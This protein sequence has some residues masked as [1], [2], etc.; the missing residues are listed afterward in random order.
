MPRRT[1][2]YAFVFPPDAGWRWVDVKDLDELDGTC[3]RCGLPLRY[4]HRLEHRAYPLLLETCLPC[5]ERMTD[6]KRAEL[7]EAEAFLRS[8]TEQRISWL[9]RRW[10]RTRRKQN[11]S[12]LTDD[13]TRVVIFRYRFGQRGGRWGVTVGGQFGEGVFETAEQAK[14]AAFEMFWEMRATQ[15]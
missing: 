9:R 12:I 4:V 10:R 8:E 2:R 11:F 7:R 5:G 15:A 6:T 1:K 13:A 14:V 3:E